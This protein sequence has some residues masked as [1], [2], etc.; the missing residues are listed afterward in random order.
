M[1]HKILSIQMKT[2]KKKKGKK[3]RLDKQK[4]NK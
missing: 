3:Y 1:E 4:E 2:E